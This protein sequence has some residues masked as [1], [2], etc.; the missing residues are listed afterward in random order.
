MIYIIY[1]P[2]SKG[3][4]KKDRKINLILE[5]YSKFTNYENSIISSPGYMSRRSSSIGKYLLN[6]EKILTDSK[7]KNTEIG[8]LNGMNGHYPLNKLGTTIREE[9]IN[10][11][12]KYHF[13]E[14]E[15][16]VN[17]SLDHRKVM[18]FFTRK[19][20]FTEIITSENLAEFL[21]TVQVNAFMIGSSNQS[22]TT[23]FDK[24][25]SKGEADIFVFRDTYYSTGNKGEIGIINGENDEGLIAQSFSVV[26]D[27]VI[28]KSFFGIGHDKSQDFMNNV[29]YELLKTGLN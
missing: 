10:L 1:L 24:I 25:A 11:F 20:S 26:R 5:K 29:L 15:M 28:T 8:L 12:S 7:K 19:T 6:L 18:C 9:H 16:N 4:D 17:K 2:K 22:N 21:E 14:I 27:S 23:Y 3:E 13:S